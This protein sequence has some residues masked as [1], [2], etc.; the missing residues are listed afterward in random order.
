MAMK[1][2]DKQKPRTVIPEQ[3]RA[4]L[5]IRRPH[6]GKGEALAQMLVQEHARDCGFNPIK[7][8]HGNIEVRVGLRSDLVFTAHLDTVHRED[9]T[10]V[11]FLIEDTDEI[12]ADGLDG[13]ASVLGADDASGVYLLLEMIKAKRPGRYLFFVGEE[14]GGIGSSAYVRDNPNFSALMVVSFDR[15]GTKNIITHQAG[16]CTA[17]NTFALALAKA[18]NKVNPEFEYAPCD[19]GMYTDSKEFAEMVPECTNISVGYYSEHTPKESQDLVHLL[20]LRDAVISIDWSA[21]P[22]SRIPEPDYPWGNYNQYDLDVPGHRDI[23]ARPSKLQMIKAC[24]DLRRDAW[25][26]GLDFTDLDDFIT[27]VEAYI[28]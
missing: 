17:S 28:V 5:S 24:T 1:T 2:Q 3:L 15:R 7:D 25:E 4:L 21:L 18:L 27:L 22:I 8:R 26:N 16:Y 12:V 19:G 14:C 11:L 9:G 10:Q 13:K 20:R 6:G 23:S